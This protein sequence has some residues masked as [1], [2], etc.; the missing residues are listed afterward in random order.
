MDLV[1]KK[2]E[3]QVQFWSLLGPILVLLSTTVL[4][5]KVSVHWYFPVSVLIG[6]PLCVK[7][8]MKGMVMALGCLFVLS[9]IGYQQL[10]LE[11]RYWHVGLALTMAFSFIVLT[12]SLEEAQGIINQ[13]QLESQSRLDNFSLLDKKLKVAEQ[14]W[15]LETEKLKS[16]VTTLTQEIAKTIDDKQTFYKLAQLAKDEIVQIRGQ[17]D[18]LLQDYLYKKEQIAQLYERLDETETT[19]QAFVNSDNEKQIQDLKTNLNILEQE[20]GS[21]KTKLDLNLNEKAA[22]E[23]ENQQIRMELEIKNATLVE[24]RQRIDALSHEVRQQGLLIQNHTQHSQKLEKIK[25]ELEQALKNTKEEL[26]KKE[27][28]EIIPHHH[29]NLPYAVG[30]TRQIESMYIQLKDQFQ[31]KCDILNETRRELFSVHEQLLKGKKE[32]E[33]EEKYGKSPNESLFEKNLFQLNEQYEEMQQF[34]EQELDELTLIVKD[35]L[36]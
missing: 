13:L 1:G 22:K 7:W 30:N 26:N 28:K 8:K 23:H 10:E 20:K 3:K 29:E 19:I 4:L 36:N 33:E 18:Q 17:H 24:H 16:E 27:Q 21:L 35:L 32:K 5:F 11:D 12:L 9:G 14:E 25:G 2:V 6:I 34:Y 31:Q 15:T